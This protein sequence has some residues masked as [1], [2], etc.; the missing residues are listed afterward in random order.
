MPERLWTQD[1]LHDCCGTILRLKNVTQ[2]KKE[3][4]CFLATYFPARLE[5]HLSYP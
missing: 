4:L 1:Q 5:K 3:G 2:K